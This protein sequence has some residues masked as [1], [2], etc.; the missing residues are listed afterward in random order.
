MGSLVNPVSS[1]LTVNTTQING[2][3]NNRVLVQNAT[4][5][6][7]SDSAFTYTG[8]ATASKVL[9]L[10]VQGPGPF[11]PYSSAG[12]T[13]RA[14]NAAITN[15]SLISLLSGADVVNLGY[16]GVNGG[17]PYSAGFSGV[18][19]GVMALTLQPSNSSAFTITGSNNGVNTSV[20]GAGYLL[21][22]S[23]GATRL[24]MLI[25]TKLHG[26]DYN[27]A[28]NLLTVAAIYCGTGVPP[29]GTG[30]NGDFAFNAAGGAGTTIY[31]KRAGAWVG[32]V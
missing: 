12:I 15:T 7:S 8:T 26:P 10:T 4:G 9:D 21:G 27:N 1:A 29:A 18:A 23:S 16:S 19:P 14:G 13:L 32:I 2:G 11:S 25:G 31:Q 28:D 24:N 22:A 6:L 30:A 3:G 17:S 5:L 20:A